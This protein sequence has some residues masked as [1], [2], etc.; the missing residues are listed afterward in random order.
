MQL[1]TYTLKEAAKIIN[2]SISS[3]KQW[4]KDL[5]GVLIIPRS[6]QGA[7]LYTNS[8]IDLLSE[9]K[10]LYLNH[11]SKKEIR[12]QLQKKQEESSE[13]AEEIPS[14]VSEKKPDP[15]PPT[16]VA[17]TDDF[18]EAMDQYKESFLNEVKDEIKKVVQT[19]VTEEVKKEITKSMYYSMK[20]LCDSIY[21]SSANTMEEI[22]DLSSTI[23]KTSDMANKAFKFLEKSMMN[24]TEDTTEELTIL[25]KQLTGATEELCNYLDFT[26]NEISNLSDVIEK[27]R[28]K[29]VKEKEQLRYEIS[30]REATFQN[31]LSNFRESASAKEKKWWKFW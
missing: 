28:E 23:E 29:Y 24:L 4:E 30:Q 10:Q 25:S 19:E 15:Y 16:A 20:S 18:F 17:I 3:I 1:R 14:M 6:R 11:F 22:K 5:R 27:E 9:I 31:M 8:E 13:A 2:V 21:K 12:D 7:R 26:N